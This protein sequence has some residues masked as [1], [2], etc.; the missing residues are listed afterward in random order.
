MRTITA[1]PHQD[2][3]ALFGPLLD[4]E[5]LGGEKDRVVE[6]LDG[7]APCRQQWTRYENAV[8]SVRRLPK[9]RAPEALA[10]AL[11]LRIRHRKGLGSRRLLLAHAKHRVPVEIILPIVLAAALAAL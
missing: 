5:L 2:I 1:K 9:E 11:A 7:C 8:Q 3:E 4:E 10:H 6:H